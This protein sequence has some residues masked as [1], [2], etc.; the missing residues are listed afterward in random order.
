MIGSTSISNGGGTDSGGREDSDYYPKLI[1]L[2][3]DSGFSTLF[4]ITYKPYKS[5]MNFCV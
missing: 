1:G 3:P 5:E 4:S 2:N